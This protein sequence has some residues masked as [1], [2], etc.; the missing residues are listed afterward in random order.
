MKALDI[1]R[2]QFGDFIRLEEKRPNIQ[3]IFAPLYHEDGDMMDIFLDLPKDGRFNRGAETQA[4]RSW[5]DTDA[6]FLYF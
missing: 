5:H 3:Q 6:S 1:L 2:A 4:I